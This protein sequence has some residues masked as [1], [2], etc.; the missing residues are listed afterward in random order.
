VSWIL[1]DSAT[2]NWV[3]AAI[4][5]IDK[6]VTSI[7]T[8]VNQLEKQMSDLSDVVT[9]VSADL[10]TL[11]TKL[12]NETTEIGKVIA[13]LQKGNPDVPAAVTALQAI[14]TRV[15]GLSSTVDQHVS[16]L[17]AALPASP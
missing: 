11:G 14:H 10:D 13:L 1:V 2:W 7:A 9:S 17:D 4:S 8:T 12:D 15:G 16:T 3:L 5:R 6:N